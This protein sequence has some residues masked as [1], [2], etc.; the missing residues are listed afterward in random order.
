MKGTTTSPSKIHLDAEGKP[1]VR[2]LA[3]EA[4]AAAWA[5]NPLAGFTIH[6]EHVFAAPRKWRFDFVIRLDS[7]FFAPISNCCAVEIEGRGRHQTV[8]GVRNDCQK[9]N[10]ALLAGWRVLRFPATDKAHADDWVHTVH[11]LLCG[12]KDVG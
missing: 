4:F 2:S 3:E 12:A 11:A 5:R 10:A 1:S 6:R 8:V 7:G 9:Y